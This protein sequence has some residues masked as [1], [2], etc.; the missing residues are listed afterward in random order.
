VPPKCGIRVGEEERTWKEGECL[1]LDDSYGSVRSAAV[2]S[3]PHTIRVTTALCVCVCVCVR[4]CVCVFVCV[5]VLPQTT[6]CG[7]MVRAI[8]SFYCLTCGIR[9]SVRVR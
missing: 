1:L 4:A 9:T 5:C 7:T 2:V 6:K 3:V 8:G